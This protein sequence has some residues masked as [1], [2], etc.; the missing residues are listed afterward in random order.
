MSEINALAPQTKL[1]AVQCDVSKYDDVKAMFDKVANTF[2]IV[3]VV[4]HAAGVL[5]PVTNIGNAPVGEW[6]SAFVSRLFICSICN[7]PGEEADWIPGNKCQGSL[8]RYS[9]ACQM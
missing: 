4:V 5:G 2:G 1:M 9:G 8:C 6:W 3:D 7:P